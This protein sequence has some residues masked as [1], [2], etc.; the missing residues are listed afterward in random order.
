MESPDP[1]ALTEKRR[2][3]RELAEKRTNKALDAIARI[4]NLSN[5]TI[6]QYEEG[7]VQKI[8]QALRDAVSVVE[9]RFSSPKA[10]SGF[11]L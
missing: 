11:K 2:K 10:R 4:A 3:F 1:Q 6:Y 8:I 9:D 7:E 5:R